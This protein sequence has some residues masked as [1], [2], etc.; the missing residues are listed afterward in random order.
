MN[1]TEEGG[2]EG[3]PPS[4]GSTAVANQWWGSIRA[5]VE[6][7]AQINVTTTRS[8]VTWGG[9]PCLYWAD[10]LAY[11]SW[12]TTSGWSRIDHWWR[13]GLTC[14]KAWANT[15]GKFRNGRF[16]ATIDTYTRHNKT[17]FEGRKYGGWYWAYDMDKWGGCSSWLHYEHNAITP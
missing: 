2:I 10:P 15:Y 13:S 5:S 11:W 9:R 16:C 7:P 3:T 6:D 1:S 8:K 14:D 17:Y 12:Y 4:A